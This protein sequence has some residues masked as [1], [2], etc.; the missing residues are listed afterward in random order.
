[1][2]S[3][4]KNVEIFKISFKLYK[5]ISISS[6]YKIFKNNKI[7]SFSIFK[8]VKFIESDFKYSVIFLF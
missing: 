8:S 3:K 2:E 4:F 5:G 7:I 6:E 1:M